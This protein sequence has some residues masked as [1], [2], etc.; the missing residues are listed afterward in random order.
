MN[1]VATFLAGTYETLI[2]HRR[3]ILRALAPT[4]KTIN[5][6]TT[7]QVK[8]NVLKHRIL[9]WRRVQEVYMAGAN[10]L[11]VAHESESGDSTE[12]AEFIKLWLPS[13]VP[14]DIYQRAC[15]SGLREKE[16]RLRYGQADDALHQLRRQLRIELGMKRYH[17]GPMGGS[18]QRAVTRAREMVAQLT[19]KRNRIVSRYRRAF[20]VL[21]RL[22][23][24]GTWTLPLRKLEG[25]DIRAPT[26]QERGL[27]EGYRELSW[28]WRTQRQDARDMVNS[29][30]E[31]ASQEEVDESGPPLALWICTDNANRGP[32]RH[33]R[34]V[35][36]QPR[37]GASLGGRSRDFTRGNEARSGLF[38]VLRRLVEKEKGIP[39][40]RSWRHPIRPRLLRI[41]AINHVFPSRIVLQEKVARSVGG[42][43]TS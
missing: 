24:V 6:Q 9:N 13:D 17:G 27:G 15:T 18:S 7:L 4:A 29:G 12:H 40:G 20:N 23:P 21:E 42:I 8:R 32:N 39:T 1:S 34:G 22:H 5:E 43:Q 33:A 36:N 19:T 3:H 16:F 35:G 14:D 25:D 28:I 26:A 2:S 11:L 41:P 38:R 10:A 30:G 31:A 37:Q